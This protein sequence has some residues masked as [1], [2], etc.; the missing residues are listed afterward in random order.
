MN[1]GMLPL[2]RCTFF[3]IVDFVYSMYNMQKK[4]ENT[5]YDIWYD[6]ID[7]AQYLVP[8]SN[9]TSGDIVT[10]LALVATVAVAHPTLRRRWLEIAGST[11]CHITV[12]RGLTAVD[13]VCVGIVAGSSARRSPPDGRNQK[14][15]C[16][17]TITKIKIMF[18]LVRYC[19]KT[20]F[21]AL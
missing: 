3:W 11:V 9:A 19:C 8:A 6:F 18:D 16:K 15:M 13:L 1:S 7:P 5:N 14:T 10:T 2:R 12:Q 4:K 21:E 20:T 17:F